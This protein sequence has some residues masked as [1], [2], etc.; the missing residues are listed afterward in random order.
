MVCDT[1]GFQKWPGERNRGPD[2]WSGA[3]KG[4]KDKQNPQARGSTTTLGCI[5]LVGNGPLIEHN[6]LMLCV[7]SCVL[8]LF[9][10]GYY[11]TKVYFRVYAHVY[12]TK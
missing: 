7:G 12:D 3:T 6:G 1:C 8:L 5:A 11:I 9:V 2:R 4:P 10:C